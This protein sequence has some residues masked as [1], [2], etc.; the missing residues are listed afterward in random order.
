MIESYD[1]CQEFLKRH[2]LE[3]P[4]CGAYF[5]PGWTKLLDELVTDLVKLGWDKQCDQIK[6]KFGALRFYIGGGTDEIWDRIDRAE[7]LSMTICEECGAPGELRGRLPDGRGSWIKTLCDPHSDGR[8]S[9]VR[10]AY[11]PFGSSGSQG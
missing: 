3:E 10:K 2:G 5:G 8:P 4:R 9:F 6:E 1:H 11:D 7:R